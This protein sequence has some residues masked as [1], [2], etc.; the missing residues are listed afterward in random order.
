MGLREIQQ[1][2][3]RKLTQVRTLDSKFVLPNHEIGF[4]EGEKNVA[5][6]I[7]EEYQVVIMS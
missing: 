3:P 1:F 2:S 4:K 6:A 5:I 7:C